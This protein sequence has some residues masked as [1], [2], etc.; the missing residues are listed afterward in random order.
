MKQNIME[1][2]G[3][4]TF[5]GPEAE[6]SEP[7]PRAPL[8]KKS[9]SQKDDAQGVGLRGPPPPPP[10]VV[11]SC[12]HPCGVRRIAHNVSVINEMQPAASRVFEGSDRIVIVEIKL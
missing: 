8:G 11:A 7:E 1:T 4:G 5:W 2:K 9:D 12:S 6:V 3:F 10:P